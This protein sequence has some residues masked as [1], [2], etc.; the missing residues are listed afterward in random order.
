MSRYRLFPKVVEK[1]YGPVFPI[2]MHTEDLSRS[3]HSEEKYTELDQLIFQL[4]QTMICISASRPP[5][6]IK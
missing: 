4:P 1:S 6:N 5:M 3:M 2:G